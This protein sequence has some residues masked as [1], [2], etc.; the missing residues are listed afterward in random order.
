MFRKSELMN[1]RPEVRNQKSENMIKWTLAIACCLFT[2]VSSQVL[3]QDKEKITLLVGASNSYKVSEAISEVVKISEVADSYDFHFYTD[4]DLASEK[5]DREIIAQSR[6][7]IVDIMHR[8]LAGYVLKNVN[9][10]KTKAY[11]VRKGATETEKIL[12]DPKVKQ[13]YNPA[14]KE[15]IKNLLLFLLNRD[16]GLDINY[17]EP[18]TVPKTGIFHPKSDKIF[19]SFK[20]YFGWYKQKGFYK[21]NGFWVGI[22]DFSSNVFPGEAGDVVSSLIE[23]LERNNINVLPVY[24]F[25]SYLAPEKFFFD[26]KGKSRVNLIAALSFKFAAIDDEKTKKNLIKL[27]V[28]LLNG[29]RIFSATIP[30]WRKSV[31]GLG[32]M[33]LTH[34]VCTPEFNGLIEPSVLGGRVVM[35]DKRTGKEVYVHKPVAEH[36]EFFIKRIKAW[37]NLQTK[38]N[39]DK[40]IAI[41]Y[42]NHTPGKQNVGASYLNVFRSLEGILKR[43]R[44]EG[45]TITGKLPSE[46]EIKNLVLKTGRNIG[47]WVPGE[48]D[49]LIKTKKVIQL[50]VSEYLKWYKEIDPDYKDKLEAEWGKVEDSKIMI[51]DKEIIIPCVNLGN[52]ILL[53]QPSRGWGDDPMK[54][55][56][57]TQLWPHHQYTAF[58]LW[59]KREFKVD[60][61]VSLGKHGTHEWLPGKQVG[62]GQSCPPEVLIQDIPNLYPYIVDNIG[63]GIQAKRRG[64]GVIIDHLIPAMKKAGAYEEYRDLSVLIDEYNDALTRSAELAREKF[65]RIK[66]MVKKLGLDKDLLL[67]EINED[68]IEEIEH[69]LIELQEANV[70]YGLHTF[71]ISPQGEALKEFSLLIKERNKELSLSEIEKKLSL[72]YLEIDRLIAGLK[73]K[74]IPSGE[75]NDPLRNPEA[76]P[77]GKN[78]Y[79]FDPAK[80]PSKDAYALGK[81]QAEE[82]IEKYL[83]EKGKYPDKIGLVF[84]S[85][86][87]QRNEGTQVGTALY[88]LG[89]KPVWDKNNKVTGVA[90]IPGKILGRPRIDVHMQTS[91]LFRDCFSHVIL[92]L[93]EAVRQAS[94]LKDVE[95]FIA[96]H[97]QKIKKYLIEKGYSKEEAENLSKIRVFSAMPGSYG[98]KTA[99]LIADS[100]LWE[101]DE[102]ISDVFINF[103]SF[104]YGKGVWGKPLKSVYKK[105]L[106]DI[107]ITMH[108]RSSNLYMTMDNDDVFQYLGG[109]SLAVKHA[110][111]EYPDVLISDQKNPDAAHIEDIERTI[112]E[113]L[114]SRYL[115]PKWIEPM[116]KENYAGAREMSRFVEFMWGWQVTTPFAI[117]ETKWEQVYEVYTEDKYNLELKEFFDEHNPWAMQSINARMLEAIRKKYWDAPDEIKKRLAVDYTMSVIEKG[118][119]CCDHICDN[120]A[121]NQMVANIISLPGMLSPA[122]VNQFQAV[123]SRATGMSLK[124]AQEKREVLQEKLA[125]ITEEIRQEEKVV[126]GEEPDKEKIEGYEMI[127]EKPEDTKITVSS[128]SWII[129]AIVI[130][131]IGLLAV[132]WRKKI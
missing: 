80:V 15:N 125:K 17:G 119:T 96:K 62:L 69:Y 87:L 123:I 128:S 47:S 103:V 115:N 60:A 73:G 52:V 16:C 89:M 85:T 35:Q 10:E 113:E 2:L 77:T 8:N 126:K 95:N 14:I 116:K 12:S 98:T 112:G 107:K 76:I 3:A 37:R 99:D 79:G 53:P 84:W 117:D 22:P 81:K 51:K 38:A 34:A 31:Q 55:Y 54:L 18:Q 64:R 44:E 72:C 68:A 26:E 19:V 114:R 29:I 109:L 41:M 6:I 57:S 70:P 28:P 9:F 74:Y 49:E 50:P 101:S 124:E 88:L 78:F 111:G 104:G 71:G 82:M 43:M 93:D 24:S 127:E 67:E 131:L 132:G 118:L 97:S 1:Q 59:L 30:E 4:K 92:L 5:I 61:I 94:Q 106:E 23:H 45:Y 13:Y 105:N 86:E 91:G 100:G 32:P 21:K 48:L 42:W 11:G 75:G 7:L 27:G 33:E 40:K 130:G 39:K 56:H 102:E 36:I 66:T 122:L 121:L 120:P 20:E 63:E 129:I 90:P 110:S 58:Y 108:T 25:P 46:E 83:K 65:K